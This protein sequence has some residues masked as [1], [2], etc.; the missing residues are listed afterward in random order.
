LALLPALAGC[1]DRYAEEGFREAAQVA[2]PAA[3]STAVW[4]RSPDDEREVRDKIASI[5]AK[6]L[7]AD[8]AVQIALMNNRGLQASFAE[9]GIKAADLAEMSLPPSPGASFKRLAGGGSVDIERQLGI[10]VIGLLARPILY[11][12]ERQRFE[13]QKLRAARSI[14]AVAAATRNAYFGAVAAAQSADYAGQVVEAAEARLDLAKRMKDAGNWSALDYAREQVFHGETL[15]GALRAKLAAGVARERLV[16]QMGLSGAE[17]KFGLAARMPDLPAAPGEER[18]IEAKAVADR[19][20]IKAAKAETESLASSLGLTRVTRLVDVLEASYVRETGGG[21]RDGYEV[22]LEVPLFDFGAAKVA[23]AENTYMQAVHRLAETAAN[24]QSE[25]REAYGRYRASYDLARRYRDDVVPARKTV[26]EELTLR[27]SGMLV[28]VF[29]LLTDARD[30][31]AT[32][33][34]AIEA[35]R[36]FWIADTDL[37]FVTLIDGAAADSDRSA[38]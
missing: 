34:A 27:Y 26:S 3:G 17:L 2:A 33:T 4:I 31:I 24:A 32:V 35:Q 25:A 16:R 28:S 1:A 23:R 21:S 11:D 9:L 8:E 30:Q 19:L 22:R 6:P 7:A 36:D 29:E 37:R 13:R 20:D 5:L 12:I 38:R 18:D 14:L 10:D 15:A